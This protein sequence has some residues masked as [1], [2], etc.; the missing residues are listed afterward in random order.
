MDNFV[1]GAKYWF[2][3]N[4][5][6]R[7][8]K[9]VIWLIWAIVGQYTDKMT[10]KYV[11]NES[12]CPCSDPLWLKWVNWLIWVFLCY[13]YMVGFFFFFFL[14]DNFLNI[15]K[16]R[17]FYQNKWCSL[18]YWW[19]PRGEKT[20]KQ[21]KKKHE[22]KQKHQPCQHSNRNLNSAFSRKV[23]YCTCMKFCNYRLASGLP[24]NLVKLYPP[25]RELTDN[26]SDYKMAPSIKDSA[27]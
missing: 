13:L 1:L 6:H 4:R 18:L 3:Y 23:T 8:P 2:L 24:F 14:C 12:F 21:T 27:V 25:P 10:Q 19:Q 17:F 15:F 26:G 16:N 20:N 11:K 5:A 7:K 9:W 22:T